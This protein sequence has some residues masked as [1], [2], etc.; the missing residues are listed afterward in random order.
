[1]Y[2]LITMR[3]TCIFRNF[4][5]LY[6]KFR[7]TKATGGE[8]QRVEKQEKGRPQKMKSGRKRWR[9]YYIPAEL[10]ARQRYISNRNCKIRNEY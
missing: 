9:I 1:M 7:C 2:I 4:G 3:W 5:R 8:D 10:P 6:I